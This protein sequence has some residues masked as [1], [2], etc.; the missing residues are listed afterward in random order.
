MNNLNVIARFEDGMQN[1]SCSGQA[2]LLPAGDCTDA[3]RTLRHA[4]PMK[5]R[6]SLMLITA[7]HTPTTSWTAS[8]SIY[9]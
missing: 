1:R 7:T 3:S 9:G 2:S 8:M 4:M 6:S 5:N